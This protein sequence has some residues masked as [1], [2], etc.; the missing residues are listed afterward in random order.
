MSTSSSANGEKRNKG[1]SLAAPK[2]NKHGKW[3]V[4]NM[5]NA[6]AMRGELN[7]SYCSDDFRKSAKQAWHST[8]DCREISL[9]KGAVIHKYPFSCC[10]LPDFV[11]NVQFL[12]EL[13]EE[14]LSL[15]F[16]EKNNDLYKFQQSEDL[17]SKK[18]QAVN[19]LKTFIYEDFRTWLIDVTGIELNT[20]VDMSSA[21]YSQTGKEL[22]KFQEV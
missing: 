15:D 3:E 17:K 16:N 21:Q 1:K 10:V 2:V 5:K 22:K 12:Y 14:L 20:K 13:K 9:E 8:E 7:V 18:N 4:T 19:A 6:K 11:G